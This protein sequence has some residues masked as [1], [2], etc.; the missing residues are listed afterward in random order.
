MQRLRVYETLNALL[1]QQDIKQV[2]ELNCGTGEDAIW[3]A[4]QGCMVLATDIAPEMVKVAAAKGAQSAVNSQLSYQAL[5]AN[6]L[7][8]LTT[9]DTYDLIFSNFGGLNCLSPEQL[10]KFVQE[11]TRLLRPDGYLVAVI[12][13][14]FCWWESL[15]FTLK[16]N[17]KQAWR[18]QSKGPVA[19][20]L[21]DNTTINTWYYSPKIFRTF[22]RPDLEHQ[23]T[24]PI[25]FWLPPSYLDPFFVNKGGFLRMLD[26]LEART[27]RF[28]PLAAGADHYLMVLRKK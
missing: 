16:L 8:T 13:S 21:D 27:S 12:M 23:Q 24:V 26:G 4:Q 1:A 20:P 3:L 7:N 25:G 22:A 11:S 9:N 10:P 15:Y 5:D 6:Q 14:S 2:L 19:A 17:S 18:R 28:A